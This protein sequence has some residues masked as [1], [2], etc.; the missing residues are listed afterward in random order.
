MPG[1]CINKLYKKQCVS[2]KKQVTLGCA[3]FF[4][5]QKR[6]TNRTFAAIIKPVPKARRERSINH[7]H[8]VKNEP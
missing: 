5:A 8:S 6:L 1:R 3:L 2:P 4:Y 7:Y